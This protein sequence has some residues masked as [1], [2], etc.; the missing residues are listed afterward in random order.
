VSALDLIAFIVLA[1]GLKGSMGHVGVSV[2][3]AG[4]SFVQMAL[5]LLAL[6]RK[7]GD[8]GGGVV[9]RSAGRTTLA[10]A[11]GGVGAWG[12]AR[13]LSPLMNGGWVV[14]MLPGLLSV[15]V[16]GGL[17]LLAAWGA[18]SPELDALVRGVR[19]RLGRRT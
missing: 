18:R 4:S 8:I 11:V 9:L 17:F 7:L 6:R 1:V 12:A 10:S 15:S 2:A 19:R 14:R 5:L 13:I 3:V 16:F